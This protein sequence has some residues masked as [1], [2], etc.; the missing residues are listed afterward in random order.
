M[1]RSCLAEA[2]Q[3]RVHV[4]P[5]DMQHL[6]NPF[7]RAVKGILFAFAV[8]L[9][10]W[11]IPAMID[12]GTGREVTFALLIV[13]AFVA[14]FLL[15]LTTGEIHYPS[16]YL[17][18]VVGAIVIIFG[19]STFF[20][21]YPFGSLFFN[22]VAA[23]RFPTLVGGIVLMVIVASTLRSFKSITF[24]LQAL[25]YS[26][27]LAG[28]LSIAH[29]LFG[30][31]LY[32]FVTGGGEAGFS[33]VGT[34]YGTAIFW[35]ALA[36]LSL[37]MIVGARHADSGLRYYA[38]IG[39]LAIFIFNMF[40]IHFQTA[41]IVFLGSAVLG[42]G[43]LLVSSRFSKRPIAQDFSVQEDLASAPIRRG[44][45]WRLSLVM[46]LMAL[47]IVMLWVKEPMFG[48]LDI[49]AEVSPLFSTTLNVAASLWE[50]E[51]GKTIILGSGPATFDYNW[52]R[53]RDARVN[54]TPFW[55]VRFTQGSSW[56]ATLLP[57]VGVLGALVF[58]A[59][60]A[61][62]VYI[63]I[64]HILIKPKTAAS[65]LTLS[66]L[67][68]TV[69][70]ILA[71]ILYPATTSFL[72]LF[73]FFC[74]LLVSLLAKLGHAGRTSAMSEESELSL[75]GAYDED[76]GLT[77]QK[78]LPWWSVEGRTIVFEKPAA[79]FISSLLAIFFVALGV[80]EAYRNLAHFRS[81]IF[82]AK[83]AQAYQE[84]RMLDAI[85]LFERSAA[86]EPRHY[87]IHQALA[88]ARTEKVRELIGDALNGKNVQEE[89]RNTVARAVENAD[90]AVELNPDNA[91]L[92]R[93]R[94]ALYETM[95]PFIAGSEILTFQNYQKAM[96]L[97]PL[98]PGAAI[99]LG[100][101]KLTFADNQFLLLSQ[102]G[103]S[104]G[105]REQLRRSRAN[106]LEEAQRALAKAADLKGDLAS[107]HFLQTQTALG[108]GNLSLAIES[109]KKAKVTAPFDIGVAFQL[110]LLYYQ[111]GDTGNAREEFERA[112]SIN[113]NYS[114][115]RY[116]LGLIYDLQGLKDAAQDQFQ[117][118]LALNPG[119][120]EVQLILA[121]LSEGKPALAGIVPPA[122]PPQDRAD[123]PVPEK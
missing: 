27:A 80:T 51:G 90:R 68:G 6:T 47:A 42:M 29:L 67:L 123:V 16:T 119:N 5:K 89:F 121:N 112:I 40:L 62:I 99:D 35:A 93:M 3:R 11:V 78:I 15:V 13:G 115:A 53:Y 84:R 94:G 33:A 50:H 111:A 66:V 56:I 19:A 20:S 103:V 2:K 106:I 117:R 71:A 41:W 43:F 69:A 114:N 55:G 46:L 91:F 58:A 4:T 95:M 73:F 7:E 44:L 37:G 101:A 49:P 122:P 9:P 120:R 59:F 22:D 39:S 36:A 79:V 14:F 98:N 74:G 1:A 77:E 108:M 31:S 32:P 18:W 118:I 85:N 24:V 116:F 57:T 38:T 100:R 34:A 113:E 17:W 107:A 52:Q 60:L 70:L 25:V 104:A 105:D 92:W 97:D 102:P 72:Y 26:G 12:A 10:V 8:L 30:V 86:I 65:R 82:F 110:G 61:L 23:E 28:L 83:G 48:D 45:D 88:Q 63:A 64:R 81:A 54:Q 75:A 109:A 96:E 76:S 87:R 21:Q